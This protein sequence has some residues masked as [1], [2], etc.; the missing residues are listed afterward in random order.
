M[1]TNIVGPILAV[2]FVLAIMLVVSGA[3]Q[4]ALEM[5]K[6]RVVA[7]RDD[8]ARYPILR[9]A[10]EDKLRGFAV[11]TAPAMVVRISDTSIVADGFRISAVAGGWQVSTAGKRFWF[12]KSNACKT[13]VERAWDEDELVLRLGSGAAQMSADDEADFR[14]FEQKIAAAISSPNEYVIRPLDASDGGIHWFYFEKK[15]QYTNETISRIQMV[16]TDLRSKRRQVCSG[17][18]RPQAAPMVRELF[19]LYGYN[20]SDSLVYYG[21]IEASKEP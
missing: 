5:A 2:V 21:R 15:Q 18:V 8:T 11:E 13:L 20:M 17:I 10:I 19:R 7:R 1:D 12:S 3:A 9:R 14:E 6:Q 16:K 4:K